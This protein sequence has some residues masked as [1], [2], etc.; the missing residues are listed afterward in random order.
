MQFTPRDVIQS[1]RDRAPRIRDVTLTPDQSA[2]QFNDIILDLVQVY[3]SHDPERLAEFTT[4]SN[5]DVTAGNPFD[6]TKS[7]MIE[8]LHILGIDWRGG[9]SDDYEEE[10]VLVTQEARNRANHEYG[11]LALPIGYLTDRDR[12]VFKISAWDGVHDIQIH[13]TLA[14]AQISP[15]DWLTVFDYPAALYRTLQLQFAV[16]LAGPLGL[17]GD[18]LQVVINDL[19]RAHEL[20]LED[21]ESHVA[22]G[23]RIEDVPHKSF[24]D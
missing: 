1:A 18:A 17:S 5:A 4:I 15:G 2:R 22:S 20:L 11:Y 14:P 6:I 8:W 21:A 3:K 13:G 9:A 10:V 24:Y 23:V 16:N 7:T 19:G 12:K